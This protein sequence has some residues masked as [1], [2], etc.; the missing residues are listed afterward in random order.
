MCRIYNEYTTTIRRVH[1]KDTMSMRRVYYKYTM[2]T[3]RLVTKSKKLRPVRGLRPVPG[4]FRYQIL[5]ETA[6]ET[7]LSCKFCWYH[8]KNEKFP[9]LGFPRTGT[10]HSANHPEISWKTRVNEYTTSKQWILYN[11]SDRSEISWRKTRG[12][13]LAVHSPLYKQTFQTAALH[14]LQEKWV[15]LSSLYLHI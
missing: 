13:P 6:S 8:K 14:L 7:F 3:I 5:T 15:L 9:G 4:L 2:S 11:L 10:S 12:L 1:D